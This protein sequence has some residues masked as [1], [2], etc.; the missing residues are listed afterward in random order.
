[1]A[2]P[3]GWAKN[4]INGVVYYDAQIFGYNRP[5][6]L[7][8]TMGAA[9]NL[10][11][12][13]NPSNG[14][15][16][17]YERQITG[18]KLIYNYNASTNKNIVNPDQKSVYQGYFTGSNQSQ[19]T[20]LSKDV[21]SKTYT[22]S[23]T[24]GGPSFTTLQTLPG[25]THF[26]PVVTDPTPPAAPIDNGGVVAP[27]S[28]LN[29]D[30]S[31][32]VDGVPVVSQDGV[33]GTSGGFTVQ[34]LPG[35]ALPE[36]TPPNPTGPPPVFRY[37]KA[38]LNVAKEIG[39]TYDYIKITCVDY[40]GS[41]NKDWFQDSNV[42]TNPLNKPQTETEA[43]GNAVKEVGRL[44]SEKYLEEQKSLG[45]VI[46]PM[47]PNLSTQNSTG[48]GEDSAN[49]LQLISASLANNFLQEA[50]SNVL[51]FDLM[52]KH[53]GNVY[54]TLQGLGGTAVASRQQ[55]A[56]MLAGYVTNTNVLQ[57]T[58]GTVINP[59]MEM[60][61]NGPKLRSFNFTFDMAPRFR[62]E[63][64]EI[65]K[66][67]RFFK[68]YM[69]PERKT[70]NA[71]LKAPKI[72]LLDYIYNGDYGQDE[73]NAKWSM[74]P[75]QHP[76][77]NKFKPCALTNFSVNYTPAGSYMTYRDGGSMTSYQISMTFSEIEP[78]YQDDFKGTDI[79][80]PDAGY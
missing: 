69:A 14:N 4:T 2:I 5:G 10:L 33:N 39:I 67:V 68:K 71:F 75:K 11:I 57:R 65:K 19:L 44:P 35:Q 55:I 76:Y 64:E 30:G 78:I 43:V 61:F 66:I 23:K 53:I 31:V 45:Y 3:D 46:L 38:N 52:K 18:D 40:I 63:A 32:S 48:W 51:S 62:E 25:Y 8:P 6:L 37:P 72:F 12:R 9:G 22:I 74:N 79:N 16:Q 70:G 29:P 49:I 21:R 73:L 42:V 50:G 17:V 80:P 58:T 60:L 59:N 77:L 15:Y 47:Q 26:S 56:A 27:P 24:I 34:P 41:L 54:Q 1:M 36:E 20:K 13:T 7:G 28:S